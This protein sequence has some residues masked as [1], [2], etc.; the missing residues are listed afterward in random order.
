MQLRHICEVCGRDEVLDSE[1]AF[2][3]GWDYPPRVGVF[4]IV[5]PRVCPNCSMDDTVWWA[6]AIEGKQHG[7]LS[8]AQLVVLNRILNEPE[9]ING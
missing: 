7:D 8:E 2:N 3:A 4:K 9:S 1:E 6:L 5:S